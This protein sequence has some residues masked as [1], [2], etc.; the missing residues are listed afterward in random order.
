MDKL[1][2]AEITPSLIID[3]AKENTLSSLVSVIAA[4][5]NVA[6][7]SDKEKLE[8]E[9]TYQAEHLEKKLDIFEDG[10]S[11]ENEQQKASVTDVRHRIEEAT[12]IVQNF[13]RKTPYLSDKEIVMHANLSD[14]ERIE[15]ALEVLNA[16][17]PDG[18][19]AIIQ[20]NDVQKKAILAAHHSTRHDKPA[21]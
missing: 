1:Q 3:G 13:Q 12:P 6:E 19:E 18:M 14:N 9:Q 2:V 17:S 10:G 16:N 8:N 7:I 4:N 20:F 11:K 15:K 21:E 5:K